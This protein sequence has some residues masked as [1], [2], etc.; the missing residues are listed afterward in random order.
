MDGQY[1]QY[2]YIMVQNV[3]TLALKCQLLIVPVI[4][5]AGYYILKVHKTFLKVL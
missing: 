5:A 4:A 1:V 2:D 3:N